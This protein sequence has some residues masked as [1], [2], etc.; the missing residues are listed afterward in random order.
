[1]T[2]TDTTRTKSDLAVGVIYADGFKRELGII[3]ALVIDSTSSYISYFDGSIPERRGD[4]SNGAALAVFGDIEALRAHAATRNGDPEKRDPQ[5]VQDE[6]PKGLRLGILGRWN[7][8]G[9]WD[10]HQQQLH[11]T[12]VRNQRLDAFRRLVL[13]ARNPRNLPVFPPD[14]IERTTYVIRTPE[15]GLH[16]VSVIDTDLTWSID[17]SGTPV[18]GDESIGFALGVLTSD[19]D[20]HGAHFSNV[21]RPEDRM[22]GDPSQP[23]SGFHRAAWTLVDPTTIVMTRPIFDPGKHGSLAEGT[24][25]FAGVAPDEVVSVSKSIRD[26]EFDLRVTGHEAGQGGTSARATRTQSTATLD[27]AALRQMRRQIDALLGKD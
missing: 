23:L 9:T 13:A 27:K 24:S 19:H 7:V 14:L 8:L 25:D 4:A 1:M 17:E 18:Q 15:R 26:G 6:L 5:A 11:D 20:S 2:T 22:Y 12:A 3:P 10:E 16:M 21:T